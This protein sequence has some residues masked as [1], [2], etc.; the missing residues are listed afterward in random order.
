MTLIFKDSW[1]TEWMTQ[2]IICLLKVI[3]WRKK[4]ENGIK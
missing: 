1:I 2:A 4:K 3:F